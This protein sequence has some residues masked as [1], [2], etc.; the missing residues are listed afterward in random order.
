MSRLLT[1]AW[2]QPHLEQLIAWTVTSG[3]KIVLILLALLIAARFA[4]ALIDKG[5]TLAVRPR[6]TTAVDV[7]MAT[8]RQNTLTGLFKA[9]ASISLTIVA[10]VMIFGELGF[11]IGPILASA[12]IV[13][14]AVGFGA[15]S[16]VKDIITGA[17]I[18]ME[19]QFSVGDVIKVGELSGGVEE[20]NLRTIVLRGVD[21]GVHIIPNG[22]I[23]C[24]TVLT[25]DW[26]RLVLDLDVAYDADLRQASAVLE[27]VLTSYA[28]DHPDVVLEA[29]EVLGVESLGEN[30]VQLRAW[31][32][33]LP[34]KQWP[35]G[36]E[37]R[38]LT[39]EAF[40]AANIEI[41]FPQRTLWIKNDP[42]NPPK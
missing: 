35:V 17:F 3:V 34:G 40:D 30:A 38:A 8:K 36:R 33:V 29:P 20:I 10:L 11:A 18:I 14:V 27:E 39:K 16:L 21:G 37:L 25:R 15:Q 13:G 42:T 41:P 19:S 24:V 5:V 1:P 7:L 32:K 12:G 9:V 31:M 6:G 4:R 23:S 28:S 2:W 26:S 22:E